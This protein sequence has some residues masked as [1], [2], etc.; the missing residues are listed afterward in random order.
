M[1][2]HQCRDDE[3]PLPTAWA[4]DGDLITLTDLAM[5]LCAGVVYADLSSAASTLCSRTSFADAC[6]V[7]P[8]IEVKSKGKYLLTY[9]PGTPDT[10]DITVK[11]TQYFLGYP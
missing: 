11:I 3:L 9:F 5:W 4:R 6:D 7:K 8:Y 1:L 2:L 10:I